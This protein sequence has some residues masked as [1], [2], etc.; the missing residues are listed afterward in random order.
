MKVIT[1]ELFHQKYCDW[2]LTVQFSTVNEKRGIF[3]LYFYDKKRDELSVFE[4][5]NYFQ[6]YISV[7]NVASTEEDAIKLI[8]RINHYEEYW[9]M[10]YEENYIA[11]DDKLK[12]DYLEF[13]H[14]D[15]GE[16]E[17]LMIADIED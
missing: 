3:L 1:K 2:D 5:A 6:L 12:E 13:V 10:T 16:L 17:D 7:G 14:G 4:V 11:I 15:C 8:Q 9:R